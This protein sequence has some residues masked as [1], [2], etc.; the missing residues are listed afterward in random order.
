VLFSLSK[1]YFHAKTGKRFRVFVITLP[2]I[3]PGSISP[4]RVLFATEAV[5]FNF[6]IIYSRRVYTEDNIF[7]QAEI[8]KYNVYEIN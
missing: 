8:F 6:G 7:F 4:E 3:K 5:T 1:Y 2:M